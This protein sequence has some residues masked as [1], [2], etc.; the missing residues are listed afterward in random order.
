MVAFRNNKLNIRA[1][2]VRFKEGETPYF[3]LIIFNFETPYFIPL[4][5]KSLDVLEEGFQDI[6]RKFWE[7]AKEKEI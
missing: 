5:T 2:S 7:K 1:W 3:T 4:K 6:E